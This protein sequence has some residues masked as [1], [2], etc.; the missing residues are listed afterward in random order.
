M[1]TVY[2]C[3]DSFGVSDPDYGECWVDLLQRSLKGR[4][5]LCVLARVAASNT[6][7]ALQVDRA[8][9]HRADFVIWLA[10][11]SVRHEV[12][13]TDI[14]GD[15]L[16]NFTD[17][18]TGISR[19]LANYSASFLK[20]HLIFNQQQRTF[21]TRYLAEYVSLPVEVYRNELIIDATHQR[22]A[23]A[24]IPYLFDQGGFDHKSFGASKT[25]DWPNRSQLC[26][27]DGI[28]A[29]MPLRPYFHITDC[30]RHKDIADYYQWQINQYL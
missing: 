7:I 10:T 3:G 25:Y 1:K 12:Q 4:A 24:Q 8:I 29:N 11:S 14:Q 26:L 23:R 22:L 17:P 9:E 28:P 20:N 21:L 13:F 2:L 5:Q 19:P 18:T 30:R 16:D 27:W 15:L 6:T